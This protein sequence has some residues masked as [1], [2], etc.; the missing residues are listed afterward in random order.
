MKYKTFVTLVPPTDQIDRSTSAVVVIWPIGTS[1]VEN[2]VQNICFLLL[3]SIS[4]LSV[5]LRGVLRPE[6]LR[7]FFISLVFL[8][9]AKKYSLI[10]FVEFLHGLVNYTKISLFPGVFLDNCTDEPLEYVLLLRA[11]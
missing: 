10:P 2:A 9:N 1:K 11:I 6:V 8:H 5:L 3:K 7:N 4:L